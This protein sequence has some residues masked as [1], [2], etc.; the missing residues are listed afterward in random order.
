MDEAG[1]GWCDLRDTRRIDGAQ[2]ERT[3]RVR[4]AATIK[5]LVSSL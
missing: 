4:S 3:T 1:A 2:A 5:S